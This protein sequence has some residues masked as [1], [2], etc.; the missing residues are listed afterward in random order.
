MMALFCIFQWRTPGAAA[1][2]LLQY[3]RIIMLLTE[4]LAGCCVKQQDAF[5]RCAR[6]H[7]SQ[8]HAGNHFRGR[9]IASKKGV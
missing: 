3:G 2:F 9:N 8:C 5:P 4:I 6:Q 1:G 7:V